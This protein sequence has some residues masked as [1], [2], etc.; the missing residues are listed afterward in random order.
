MTIL[1][2]LRGHRRTDNSE[3]PSDL[4]PDP[5]PA[6]DR[7]LRRERGVPSAR[8]ALALLLL[9]IVLP[10]RA[11]SAIARPSD[12]LVLI[13]ASASSLQDIPSNVL[14]EAFQGLRTAYK[15]VRI[16]PFNLPLG[17]PIRQQLDRAVLGLE[18]TE[19][20][21]FWVDQ[22]VRDGRI[23]PRTVASVE[24]LV[25]VVAQLPGAV[26][27]VP[28]SAVDGSVRALR[29]DGRAPTDKDYLLARH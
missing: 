5:R 8:L 17:T 14:R 19:V 13:S 27:C 28:A 12:A 4:S 29:I 26:A 1:S 3:M 18:P 11:L 25:R 22:R 6:A 20:G 16:I 9:A 15:G 7:R 2:L 10:T 23:A 24:R 21:M